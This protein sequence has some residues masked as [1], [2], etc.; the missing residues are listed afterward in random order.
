MIDT[1]P[2]D[3]LKRVEASKAKV[4]I[5]NVWATWCDP[6]REELPDF[7][8]LARD[9]REKGVEL[10]LLS[11]DFASERASAESFLKSLGVDFETYRKDAG[12]AELI[13]ALNKDW[14]GTLP[15]TFIYSGGK[16]VKFLEG[17]VTYTALERE[18]LSVLGRA[19]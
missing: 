13:D 18:V 19:S 11:G 16:Q 15:A 12:D 2:A 4:V 7:L 8:K 10:V 9:Y 6:C 17:R 3:L 5:V 14:S 1:T